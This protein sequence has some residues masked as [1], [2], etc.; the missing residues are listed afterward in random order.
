MT[1]PERF[2]AIIIGTGQGGKPL[3]G[4]LARAGWKTAIIEREEKVGGTCVVVGCT[5]TKTMIASARVAYLVRRAAEYGINTG[6]I[7]VDQTVVRKRKR[8]IVE[9]FSSGSKRGMEKLEYNELIMGEASFAGPHE[10]EVRLNTG[11]TRRLTSDKI[12]INVGARPRAPDIPGLASVPYLNSTTVM[13]LGIVPEHLLVLGGGF[14]GL[15]F[16]QLFRRLGARVTI[17]EMADRL[18]RKEDPDVSEE[19]EKIFREDGIEVVLNSTAQ[20]VARANGAIQLTVGGPGGERT[21]EGS[22]VLVSVGRTP[23]SDSLNVAAAGIEV[24]P[25]G[26]IPV[27]ERLETNV[28]GVYAIGDV[29]GGP[30]FTHISYDDFRILR[31]NFLHGANATTTGRLVPYAVF[32]DPQLARVGL[33][34][35]QARTDGLNIKVAKMPMS[36]VARALEVDETRGFMKAVIDADTGRILGCTVFGIEGGEL[37]SM[38]EIAMLGKVPYA[39]LRDAIYAHPTLAEAFNNLFAKLDS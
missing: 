6:P 12:V 2:D 29:N 23:N 18:A 25:N 16:G 35:V 39:V 28:A 32:I 5:P 13:E 36:H 34:E 37:M 24:K 10:I 7:S 14:I 4:A 20:R 21:L 33:T 3:A 19:L 15:E 11:G 8:D 26:L 31:D 1:A 9:M 30:P 27:N 22:H 17:T 38:L